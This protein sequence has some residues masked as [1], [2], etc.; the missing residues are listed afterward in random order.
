MSTTKCRIPL[1][2]FYGHTAILPSDIRGIN[3]TVQN[4][5]T[6]LTEGNIKV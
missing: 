5:V 3:L 1:G 4:D 2:M 6:G